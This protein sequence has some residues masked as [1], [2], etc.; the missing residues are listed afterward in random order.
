[1]Q[2]PSFNM[3]STL[4]LNVS[5]SEFPNPSS[6]DPERLER[7]K[8]PTS[9]Q[10]RH[11]FG[12]EGRLLSGSC[13]LYPQHDDIHHTTVAGAQVACSEGQGTYPAGKKVIAI[14]QVL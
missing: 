11:S 13:R 2:A 3:L 4:P 12:V 5:S 7:S 6:V 14:I 1:M 10:L 9:T 8:Q